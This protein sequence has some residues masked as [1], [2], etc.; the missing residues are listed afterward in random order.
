ML[1]GTPIVA[2][3]QAPSLN[4]GIFSQPGALPDR[5]GLP[6]PEI[7]VTRKVD[8]DD[9]LILS[10]PNAIPVP[11]RRGPRAILTSIS[12]LRVAGAGGATIC[13]LVRQGSFTAE[14]G[15][16][17]AG[18]TLAEG[19]E[20]PS[21]EGGYLLVFSADEVAAPTVKTQ[22]H[23]GTFPGPIALY[24]WRSL[25]FTNINSDILQ[26]WG[27]IYHGGNNG[28]WVNSIAGNQGNI[29]D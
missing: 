17:P 11:S 12:S 22:G 5:S 3:A 25:Y 18:G 26:W 7:N 24:D 20:D 13:A 10:V 4:R 29:T 6:L 2:A 8:D 27:W 28:A 9:T 15:S 14:G 21:K 16:G 23:I 1:I 19:N